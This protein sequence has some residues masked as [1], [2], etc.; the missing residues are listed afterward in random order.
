MKNSIGRNDPC[1]CG[2][3]KKYKKCCIN[4]PDSDNQFEKPK[5]G[6]RFEAGS[7]GDIGDFMPSVACLKQQ[8]ND[9]IHHFVL[10]KL[11]QKYELEDEASIQATKDL[12]S[13][14]KIKY[15]SGSEEKMA[16]YLKDIGYI[17]VDDFNIVRP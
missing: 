14:F 13:A 1:P 17:K 15:Q 4:K 7:Y 12:D 9:W 5:V 16:T 8:Q 11:D 10:V 2:S 6:F 3:G